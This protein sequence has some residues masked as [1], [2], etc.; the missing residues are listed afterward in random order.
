MPYSILKS[1]TAKI[2]SLRFEKEQTRALSGANEAPIPDLRMIAMLHLL[3]D[4]NCE[5]EM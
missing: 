4:G 1:V 3:T 2:R 5:I